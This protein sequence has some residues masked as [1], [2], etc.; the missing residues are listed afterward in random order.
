MMAACPDENRLVEYVEGLLSAELQQSIDTHIDSCARCRRQLA[1]FARGSVGGSTE[2]EPAP[3]GVLAERYEL[4]DL[5]GTGGMSVVYA[6]RDRVLDRMVAL[7]LLRDADAAQTSRLE[8]EARAMAQLAHPNVLPVFDVGAASGR[9]FLTAELV[10]GQTLEQWLRGSR[11]WREIVQLF[12][13]AG[14]GLA[15]AHAVGIAHRDFKPSNMLIGTDGRLRV[16][17]FGLA[18][19]DRSSRERTALRLDSTLTGD[20]IGTPLYMAPEQLAGETAGPASDQFAFCVSLFE[21]LHGHRPFIAT[22][23]AGLRGAIE[24]GPARGKKRVPRR[25]QRLIERGLAVEASRR[26]PAMTDVVRELERV[27]V[28]PRVAWL[29]GA[30]FAVVA[31][32]AGV[33]AFGR[34]DDPCRSAQHALDGIW[35]ASTRADLRGVFDAGQLAR[36]ASNVDDY[37]RRWTA[38]RIEACEATA[39][40]HTQS[41]ELLDLRMQCLDRRRAELASLVHSWRDRPT[42]MQLAQAAGAVLQLSGLAGCADTATLAAPLAP[43]ADPIARQAAAT[44]GQRLANATGLERA[45]RYRDALALTKAAEAA[46]DALGHAPLLADAMFRRARLEGAVGDNK[47]AAATMT[48]AVRRAAIARDDKLVASA[49][50]G[51]VEIVG[52]RLARHEEGLEL[53]HSAEV[54]ILRAG[55]DAKQRAELHQHRGMML[56][57][58]DKLEAALAEHRQALELRRAAFP[59]GD[60]AIAQSLHDIAEVERMAGKLDDAQRDHEQALAIREHVLGPDHPLVAVSLINLGHTYTARDQRP[61]ARARYARALA[62]DE[63]TLPATHV[64]IANALVSLA[65]TDLG[66]AAWT[67]ALG[68]LERARAIY[69]AALGESHP[70]LSI[71]ENNLGEAERGLGHN[72]AAIAHYERALAID[73]AHGSRERLGVATALSNLADMLYL[74]HRDA[75]AKAKYTEALATFRKLQGESSSLTVGPLTGLAQVALAHRDTRTAIPLLE[76]A[77]A[78]E[79]AADQQAKLRGVLAHVRGRKL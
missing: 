12:V 55:N 65:A 39:V 20:L 28:R 3:T 34:H 59:A 7:K 70:M 36:V 32:A 47:A 57:D 21:A 72:A 46:A 6:A 42:R 37:A 79:P 38:M 30:A 25:L 13:Q 5:V 43:P 71:V 16:A 50:L 4:V 1:C 68:R 53:A 31:I 78:L 24:R 18:R 40:H 73:L 33:F 35:D 22:S 45:G 69:V 29:A 75:E 15:A 27:L 74:E 58:Q 44:I 48:E 76:R 9:T 54:A 60:L 26:W 11:S 2:D 17:D 51:L 10:V 41:P 67:T 23:L 8:R 19:E 63:R 66:D 62:I 49:W 14:R 61:E 52:F 64:E 77:I 56:R